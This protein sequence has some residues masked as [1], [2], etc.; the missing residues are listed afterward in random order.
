MDRRTM[1]ALNIWSLDSLDPGLLAWHEEH[2]SYYQP[3]ALVLWWCYG[4]ATNI[5]RTNHLEEPL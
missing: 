5:D 1:Q 2:D 3:I 4:G